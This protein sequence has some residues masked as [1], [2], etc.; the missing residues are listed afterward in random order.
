M[1]L[2]FLLGRLM[3]NSLVNIDMES[4]YKNALMDIGYKLEDLYE[5]EVDPAL[6]NGGLGRLAACF[7]DSM[8]SLEVP[9]WG[10]GIRY[11]YG[12]FKQG[13]VD[14]Y[15]VES[16]DYWLAR[17]N[18]WEIERHDI[19]YPVRFYGHVKKYNDNGVERAHWEGGEVVQA[20]A[21]DTPIPG[22]N[23]FNT[24]NLRLWKSRPYS[25]FDFKQFNAGDYHGAIKERQK[26][27]YIT[28]V[29][30]PNDSSE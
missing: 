6:G 4:K 22:F 24:N 30:Y 8:A 20:C 16:P 9:A 23:T 7:L 18:P 2:E 15:Q 14:G 17:G 3:Q 1:S 29:L 26:A 25:E 21:F 28:S 10:Y 5:E 19:H 13:I 11:D 12:I 27:E